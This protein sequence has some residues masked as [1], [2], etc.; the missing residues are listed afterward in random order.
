MLFPRKC[1]FLG[2]VTFNEIWLPGNCD[3]PG[4]ITSPEMWLPGK[5]HFP[6]KVTSLEMCNE[7]WNLTSRKLC[8]PKKNDF[9]ENVINRIMWLSIKFDVLGNVIS[10]KI[11]FYWGGLPGKFD[12]PGNSTMGNMTSREMRQRS[13]IDYGKY[14]IPGRRNSSNSKTG[15][16]PA[17]ANGLKFADCQVSNKKNSEKFSFWSQSLNLSSHFKKSSVLLNLFK[18]IIPIFQLSSEK[19]SILSLSARSSEW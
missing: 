9:P 4:N 6:E 10:H 3:F 5:C 1:D 13:K 19:F 15:L 8:F 11:L 18:S 2:S 16:Y 17:G 12:N 14:D 7:I